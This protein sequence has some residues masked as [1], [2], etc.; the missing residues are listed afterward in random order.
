MSDSDRLS[1]VNHSIVELCRFFKTSGKEAGFVLATVLRTEG[2]TYRKA[3]ATALID[4]GGRASGMLSGGCLEADLH[5]RAVRALARGRSERIWYD[6]RASQDPVWG[7]GSGCEGA[8]DIWLQPQSPQT[9]FPALAYL[10]Q[11]LADEVTARLATVVGGAATRAELGTQAFF[12]EEA[13]N[14]L[15]ACLAATFTESGSDQLRWVRFEDRALEVFVGTLA[16]P[17]RLLVCGAG[18]DA[19]PVHDF[20]A[21]LGWHV[22]VFD[23]RPAYADAAQFPLASRVLCARAEDIARRLDPAAFDAAI[24]MSHHLNADIAYLRALAAQPPRY[25]GLL[26]PATRRQRLLAEAGSAAQRIA[27]RIHGPAGL[28][29]GAGTPEAIAL[30]IVAQIQAAIAGKAGG[31][32]AVT[33]ALGAQSL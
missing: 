10:E 26:G 9:G 23:H 31:P 15:A 22:T 32:F 29:I 13:A 2:S 8:M 20:A 7:I 33:R 6:T 30:A 21:A 1:N 18:L 11:C 28:D 27:S 12:G 5:E 3:G 16:L 25:I 19:I 24:I 17:P 14:P 4:A